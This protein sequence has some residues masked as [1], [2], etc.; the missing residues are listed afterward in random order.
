MSYLNTQQ[1]IRPCGS[2]WAYCDGICIGCTRLNMSI[3][4]STTYPY[5]PPEEVYGKVSTTDGKT[6]W[7][8]TYTGEHKE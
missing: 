1:Q 6:R 2:S 5:H 4:T 3:V 8:G 7:Y